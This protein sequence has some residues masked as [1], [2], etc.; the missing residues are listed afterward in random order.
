MRYGVLGCAHGH[1]NGFC[2]GM[3]AAGHTLAAVWDDGTENAARLSKQYGAPLLP[4][5]E[6]VIAA[7][8]E[9]AGTFAPSFQR[10]RMILLCEKNNFFAR[11]RLH[12][13]LNAIDFL[14]IVLV[15]ALQTD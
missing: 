14:Y 1:V 4:S 13:I 9:V 3:Q 15:K 5:P 11:I 6:E 12:Y 10:I 7:G 8:I 2:A